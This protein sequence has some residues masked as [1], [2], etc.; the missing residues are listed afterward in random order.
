MNP[1]SVISPETVCSNRNETGESNVNTRLT[2]VHN[3]IKVTY[4]P[5]PGSSSRLISFIVKLSAFGADKL[6]SPIMMA[7]SVRSKF[8]VS[9]EVTRSGK[10][11]CV[12]EWSCPAVDKY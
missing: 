9:P 1:N 2:K 12:I 5:I 10:L 3:S 6:P 8:T 4:L 7:P 11:T